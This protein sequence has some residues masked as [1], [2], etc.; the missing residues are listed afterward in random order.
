MMYDFGTGVEEL[1]FAAQSFGYKGALPFHGGDL[2]TLASE[3]AEGHPVVVSLG[4]NAS[5][6]LS[7]G[8]EGQPG[9][10]VTVT[11]ISPDGDWIAFNDPTLGEQVLSTS[12]FMRLWGLQ[13]NSG[14]VVAPDLPPAA[15]DPMPWVALAAGI[16][17][18]VS[19]T[20][21]GL[22]RKG[23]GGRIT[24]GT[25][26]GS[27]RPT[28]KPAPK[29]TPKSAPKPA[30]KLA[31]KPAA[32]SHLSTPAKSGK[33]LPPPPKLTPKPTPTPDYA[34]ESRLAREE[35]RLA[36]ARIGI[37]TAGPMEKSLQKQ[38]EPPTLACSIEPT[39]LRPGPG[40]VPTPTAIPPI[41]ILDVLDAGCFVAG[42]LDPFDK[43]PA[44]VGTNV[45]VGS[46]VDSLNQGLQAAPS[47]PVTAPLKVVVGALDAARDGAATISN[48]I[49]QEVKHEGTYYDLVPFDE[50][51]GYV[52]KKWEEMTT[53]Q[54]ALTVGIVVAITL[55]VL[56]IPK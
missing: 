26:T 36:Q 18:L 19:T 30:L 1:A 44:F 25:G 53:P 10:F 22:Q 54:K 51:L 32:P 20:P 12:E 41:S 5:T 46:I 3:L 31:P 43:N 14:V 45:G 11:G 39:T 23:I 24:A 6:S 40:L 52:T 38:G 28:P 8:G 42:K 47:N 21:L 50:H 33:E 2:S 17:A 27:S 4:S 13:G 29:P 56:A 49:C 34:A 15:P 37:V 55:A 9:H 48:V 16:M 35:D 7:T